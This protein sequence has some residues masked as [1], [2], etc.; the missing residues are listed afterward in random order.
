MDVRENTAGRDGDVGETLVELFVVADSELDM[1]GDDPGT[2]VVAGGVA[3]QL[4]DFGGEVLEDSRHVDGGAS[5][6]AVSNLH[7]TQVTGDTTDRELEPGLG[8]A[9]SA[10]ALRFT[11]P[12]FTFSGHF[13]CC[14]LVPDGNVNDGC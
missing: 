5:A 13:D 11:T 14:C 4:E 9:R 10:L 1:P 6:E 7:A 8:R 12:C 3:G 2:L